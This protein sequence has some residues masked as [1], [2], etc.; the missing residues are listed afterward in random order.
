MGCYS[1]MSNTLDKAGA[2]NYLAS[3]VYTPENIQRAEEY[4]YNVRGIDPSRMEFPCALT[5]P[6]TYIYEPIRSIY[7]P[8][9]FTDSLFIPI[10]DVTK[11]GETALAGFDIRYLGEA[12]YRTR[13]QKIKRDEQTEM[14][15]GALRAV[16]SP[17]NTPLIVTEGV[18]DG[19]SFPKLDGLEY[20]VVSPLTSMSAHWFALF[21]YSLSDNIW[22]AYDNDTDGIKAAKKLLDNLS[23]SDEVRSCFKVLTYRGKDPNQGLLTFGASNLRMLLESQLR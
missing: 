3:V 20:N 17:R 12:T 9:M 23:F 22:I 18:I 7:P 21:L 14:I 4:L 13:Y 5:G 6:E 2:L 19:E 8:Y 15:Y 11:S 10:R 1:D 16:K